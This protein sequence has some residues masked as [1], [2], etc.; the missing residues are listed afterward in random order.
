VSVI[1]LTPLRSPNSFLAASWITK[2]ESRGRQEK[3]RGVR[4]AVKFNAPLQCWDLTV[5]GFARIPRHTKTWG[6]LAN[7]TT[8]SR[9]VPA[10][11]RGIEKNASLGPAR[12]TSR[13]QVRVVARCH[14][15]FRDWMFASENATDN[16]S[17]R[18]ERGKRDASLES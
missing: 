9:S 10:M 1:G 8:P 16:P 13:L 15:F 7:S 5:V 4:R 3:P 2:W 18:G 11:K 14:D 12:S 6:I 17:V